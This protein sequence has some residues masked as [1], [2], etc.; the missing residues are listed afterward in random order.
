MPK[1]NTGSVTHLVQSHLSGL[2]SAD[3]ALVTEWLK[4]AER[5]N[6]QPATLKG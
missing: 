5:R 1:D 3:Q 2:T 6:C 4:A